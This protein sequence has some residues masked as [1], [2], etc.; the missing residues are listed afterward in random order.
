MKKQIAILAFLACL[1]ACDNGD[2]INRPHNTPVTYGGQIKVLQGQN[3]PNGTGP[4]AN[5][6]ALDLAVTNTG[7]QPMLINELVG[8]IISNDNTLSADVWVEQVINNAG[9][10]TNV[11]RQLGMAMNSRANIGLTN[12]VVQP[13]ETIVLRVFM[14]SAAA[15]TGDMLQFLLHGVNSSGG[16]FVAPGNG[17]P[18]QPFAGPSYL[19]G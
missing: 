1:T 16:N 7:N 11:G 3:Q 5:K 6:R 15:S 14:T 19:A 10:T 2:D 9:G 18:T 12:V 8:E 13:G 4:I 17:L